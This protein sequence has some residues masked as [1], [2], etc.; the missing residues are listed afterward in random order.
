MAGRGRPGRPARG[1][2]GKGPGGPPALL[3][4]PAQVM[5]SQPAVRA[6]PVLLEDVAGAQ[7]EDVVGAAV[8]GGDVHQPGLGGVA[9]P[10]LGEAGAGAGGVAAAAGESFPA[11]EQLG[12]LELKVLHRH[13][14]YSGHGGSPSEMICLCRGRSRVCPRSRP[15]W[16][17]TAG[18]PVMPGRGPM[19]AG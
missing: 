9:V 5:R 7:A 10:D 16:A 18:T 14:S 19:Y 17:G 6:G 12:V 4:I 2:P 8:Q 3:R 15:G 13:G 1:P 11:G